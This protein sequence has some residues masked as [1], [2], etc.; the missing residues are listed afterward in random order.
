[1]DTVVHLMCWL[2]VL[3]LDDGTVFVALEV[4]TDVYKPDVALAVQPLARG[5]V[6]EFFGLT[7]QPE[8]LCMGL[9]ELFAVRM[10]TTGLELLEAWR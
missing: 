9:C 3:I 8:A 1:M 7:N 5:A 10:C 2:P 6:N 4:V